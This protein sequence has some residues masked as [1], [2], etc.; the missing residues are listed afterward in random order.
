MSNNQKITVIG[1]AGFVG[2]NFCQ[3][4]ADHQV[5]FETVDL[6]PSKRF[7]NKCQT[8]DIVVNLATVHRDD[9]HDKEEYTRTNVLGAENIARICTEKCIRKTIFTSTVA[10]Y[11]F[12]EPGTDKAGR[13][14]PFNEYGRTKVALLAVAASGQCRRRDRAGDRQDAAGQFEPDSQVL[15]LDNLYLHQAGTRRFRSSPHTGGRD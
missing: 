1:R 12:A 2:T 11:G 6:K 13:I 8:S 4:L 14:N 3:L 7:Q 5:P 9:I 10:V 15:C